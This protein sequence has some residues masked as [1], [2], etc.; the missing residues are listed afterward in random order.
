VT[1]VERV[2]ACWPALVA[3]VPEMDEVRESLR[4]VVASGEQPV[5]ELFSEALDQAES[6]LGGRE[7]LWGRQQ[8]RQALL[9][10]GQPLHRWSAHVATWPDEDRRDGPER[11]V[12][13]GEAWARFVLM[14]AWSTA[15]IALLDVSLC[16]VECQCEAHFP[17][18]VLTPPADL[19]P[20][21]VTGCR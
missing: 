11:D 14:E 10:P 2:R 15:R 13:E 1:S 18:I 7:A 17:Q 8:A 20:P 6:L 19:H 5:C 21:V 9:R 3:A 4:A 16:V 12:S